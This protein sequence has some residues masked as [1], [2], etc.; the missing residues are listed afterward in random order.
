[1]TDCFARAT[2]QYGVPSRVRSDHGTENVGVWQFMDAV[3]GSNRHS[4]IAGRSVH[5]CRIERLRRDVHT[6]VTST[7][8][9]VFMD[10]ENEEILDPDNDTDIFC[11]HYIFLP[12]IN[13]SLGQFM[14]AWNNHPLS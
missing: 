5:N 3:R 6:V 1:M 10:M 11:L 4:Y 9:R 13:Q 8:A 7:Y 14:A 12:R 2:Q